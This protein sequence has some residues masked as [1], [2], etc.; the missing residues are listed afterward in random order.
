MAG[1]GSADRWSVARGFRPVPG[2]QFAF[3]PDGANGQ[4]LAWKATV[5]QVT[6][7]EQVTFTLTGPE[8]PRPV[9]AAVTLGDGEVGTATVRIHL[10]EGSIDDCRAIRAALG[11]GWRTRLLHEPLAAYLGTGQVA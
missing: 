11:E 2:H 6:T 8:L 9:V 4:P 3:Y 1:D 7:G 10:V 5:Q